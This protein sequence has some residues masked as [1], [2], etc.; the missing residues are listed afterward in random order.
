MTTRSGF[1]PRSPAA[2][3][4]VL[5]HMPT[6]V[7]IVAS[8]SADRPIGVSVGSF[9]SVSL[10][11]PL[12][13]FFITEAS[14]TWPLIEPTG[15]FCVSILSSN[16]EALC[17]LFATR[18]ADKFSGCAWQPSPSGRP[19]IDGSVAWIDC[20]IESMMRAGD[21]KLVLGRVA[22]MGALEAADP[23][24]FLGGRYGR[25]GSLADEGQTLTGT[26]ATGW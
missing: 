16:Q 7:A 19:I 10:D 13:G 25:I 15:G 23:L 26:R 2:Y 11:P 12:V 22:S 6:G 1:D 17:R 3:R 14:T 9:S 24:V 20:A 5:G 18:G 8:I 21:H 4:H